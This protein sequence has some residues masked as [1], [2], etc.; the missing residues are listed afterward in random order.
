MDPISTPQ[1]QGPRTTAD[2]KAEGRLVVDA[3]LR[4]KKKKALIA[5]VK[6]QSEAPSN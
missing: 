1:V 6:K 4:D 5:R 3:G 2:S